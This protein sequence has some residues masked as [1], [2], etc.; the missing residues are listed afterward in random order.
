MTMKVCYDPHAGFNFSANAQMFAHGQI[1]QPAC[2]ATLN[3]KKDDTCKD[4]YM[5][6]IPLKSPTCGIKVLS[7]GTEVS[8]K[9]TKLDILRIFHVRC[10][11]YSSTM[12]AWDW[13]ISI[14]ECATQ[15]C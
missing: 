9:L 2:V 10:L 13:K 5:V 4:K 1:A 6:E 3:T 8:R 11:S 15:K 7:P 12:K 14:H